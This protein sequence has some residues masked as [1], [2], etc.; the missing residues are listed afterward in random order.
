[1]FVIDDALSQTEL[2]AIRD[3]LERVP[4]SGGESTAGKTAARVK[5]NEQARGDDPE[6]IALGRRVRRSLEMH[7]LIRSFVRPVRWSSLLFSRYRPAQHY[8]LHVDNAA[9]YDSAGYPLRTDVS[10]TVFLSDPETYEGGALLIRSLNED[11][12]FRPRAGSVVVYPTGA[13]HRVTPVTAGV[14]LTCVGWVQSLIR[15]ED[16]RE[17]LFDLERL[18]I[19]TADEASLVLDK[20]IGNLLRMWGED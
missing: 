11:R 2:T 5:H 9:M 15:R 7:P 18:R 13:V 4:F 8:G 20:T 6:V 3:V 10:F 19:D 1:M 16:Q 17:V 12:D 14:R